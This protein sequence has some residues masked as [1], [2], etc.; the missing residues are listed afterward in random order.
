M[1]IFLE[2]TILGFSLAFI[3]GFGPAF[4]ALIQT[5]IYRG[6]LPGILLAFGIFLNDL[7][8]VTASIYGATSLMSATQNYNLMGIIGGGLLIV[9][10][11]VTYSRKAKIVEIVDNPETKTPHAMVYIGKGFLLNTL[12]P[13]VWIFWISIIVGITARY[14]ADTLKLI[15]F[16]SGTLSIVLIT[17]IIKTFTAS[18][19]K[20]FVT[21]KILIL[22]NKISGLAI[23]GF[24]IFLLIKS[25]MLL[26]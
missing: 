22:I 17:D 4:F 5:G 24:G 2:G 13:F 3:F 19:L 11:I 21:D 23:T 18:L 20:K 26:Y 16:F 1:D 15:L 7:L 14:N 8:I 6:F 12:N 10:G 25:I 9:L